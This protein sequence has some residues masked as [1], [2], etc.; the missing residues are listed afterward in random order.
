MTDL[1][2]FLYELAGRPW[3]WGETDCLMVLANWIER[4]HGIDP[5][6]PFRGTY[7]DEQSCRAVLAAHGGT[8]ALVDRVTASIGIERLVAIPPTAGDIA[9][10]RAP[11]KRR[12]AV[13]LRDTGAICVGPGRF[14]LLTPD[15]GVMIAPLP[16]RAAWRV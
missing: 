3:R 14:A 4:V 6:E 16:L 9:V 15:C 10:V 5:G 1:A 11:C 12:D 7:N 13:A 8:L 2:D